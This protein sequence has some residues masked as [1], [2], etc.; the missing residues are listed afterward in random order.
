MP[1]GGPPDA[2]PDLHSAFHLRFTPMGKI[3]PN[4]KLRGSN[5]LTDPGAAMSRS[6]RFSRARHQPRRLATL[7]APGL[8][9]LCASPLWAQA[10][11]T[12]ADS[13]VD[14]EKL[15]VVTVTATRRREP[16]RDVPLRVET[17]GAEPME[18]A[19]AT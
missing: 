9:A 19:G 1:A 7:L 4:W 3:F 10:Q 8:A 12:A 13:K 5:N 18:R 11:A 2:C 16:V 15:D 14:V 6:S 17:L